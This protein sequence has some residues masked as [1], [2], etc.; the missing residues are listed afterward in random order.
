MHLF[1]TLVTICLLLMV[2]SELS[3]S[4]FVDPTAW[5]L[6]SQPQAVFLSRYAAILGRIMPFWYGT[7]LV[8]LIAETWINRQGQ[9][10]GLLVAASTLWFL[11]TLGSIVFLVP[12]NN[13]VIAATGDWQ[14]AHHLWDARHRIRVVVLALAAILFTFVIVR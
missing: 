7:G 5:R 12:L 4:A 6:D 8:M 1:N 9:A 2:G 13:R 3:V 10:F 11:T 14:A